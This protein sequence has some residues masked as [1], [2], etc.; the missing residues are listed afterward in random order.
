[1]HLTLQDLTVYAQTHANNP[2]F[3]DLLKAERAAAAAN[4]TRSEKN[5]QIFRAQGEL[6]ALDRLIE[7][8]ETASGALKKLQK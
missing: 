2:R 4:L 1:M 7:N 3:I 8:L 6:T 5:V